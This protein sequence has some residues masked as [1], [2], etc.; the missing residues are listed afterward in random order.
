MNY[1]ITTT[2]ARSVTGR[3][4]LRLPLLAAGLWVGGALRADESVAARL[5]AMEAQIK[6]LRAEN[7][8]LRR[9]LGVDGKA[10]LTFVKPAGKEPVLTINGLVQAQGEF[11]DKGDSRWGS[12]NDRFFLR[13]VRLGA[14]GKFLEEFDF[15]VEAEFAN[16]LT[17]STTAASAVM[18][19]GF[20]NWSHFEWANV[21][22]GQFKTP[23]GY[24]FLLADPKLFTPER[25]LGSDRLT[26]NRQVGAQVSGDLFDKRLSYATGI[27]NGT[28]SNVSANDNDN[29]LYMGR[30]AATAWSGRLFGQASRLAVGADGF[31]SIDKGVSVASDFGLTSNAFTGRRKGVG[32]DAQVSFGPLDLSA[33]YLCVQFNPTEAKPGRRFTSAAWFAQGACFVLPKTLQG[34]VRYET[35]DPNENKL[36]NETTSWVVGVNWLLKG[37]DL[38]LQADYVFTHLDATNDDQGKLILRTQVIF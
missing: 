15:K 22:V 28:G 4:M 24:E 37:D 29:F 6:A 3:W 19:D 25:S 7:Q 16:S 27:F 21:K 36:A 14:A 26:L 11:G 32:A 38:K 33:E 35:F 8:A 13:R 20:I 31:T 1:Y 23:Y 18:M 34:V 30:V 17:G 12:A 2:L 9:E 5:D 10:G